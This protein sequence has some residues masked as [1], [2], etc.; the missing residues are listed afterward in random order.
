MIQ[1]KLGCNMGKTANTKAGGGNH[2]AFTDL[3]S[4]GG[5]LKQ[6]GFSHSTLLIQLSFFH[7]SLSLLS[8][9]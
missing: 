7:F 8:P 6:V 9:T 1:Y 5:K 4:D 3:V 2:S